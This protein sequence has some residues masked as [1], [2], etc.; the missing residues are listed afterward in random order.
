MK[1]TS[2]KERNGPGFKTE[3]NS[4]KKI[5]DL[6]Y[7]KKSKDVSQVTCFNCN[8]KEYYVKNCT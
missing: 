2:Q 7:N 1:K 4:S 8:Q 6:D 3:C 5:S